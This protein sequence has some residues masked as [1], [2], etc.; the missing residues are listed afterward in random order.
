MFV[1]R[2]LVCLWVLDWCCLLVTIACCLQ[3]CL[4]AAFWCG[5]VVMG[6]SLVALCYYLL[7][8]LFAGFAVLVLFMVS[9]W[10]VW[11]VG[12]HGVVWGCCCF[13]VGCYGFGFRLGLFDGYARF[14]LVAVG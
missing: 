13:W 5:F 6:L 11:F 12:L 10:T 8:A 3:V 2:Q 4:G 7:V 14:I 9:G 1:C